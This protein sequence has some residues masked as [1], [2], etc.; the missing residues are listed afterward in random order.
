MKNKIL[1]TKELVISIVGI[2]L[3]SCLIILPPVFR[4]TFKREKPI[5]PNEKGPILV[6]TCSKNNIKN[7]N[8]TDNQV[9]S[10]AHQDGKLIS[11]IDEK[12]RIY[13]DSI[14]YQSE[15]AEYGK[16]V[17]ALTII[18]GYTYTATPVDNTSSVNIKESFDLARFADTTIT[19]PGS[20]DSK[21]VKSKYNY[22]AT[23]EDIQ[24]SLVAQG[25]TCK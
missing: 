18:D 13:Y 25:Y 3:L 6:L 22:E 1:T 4:V 20:S 5:D 15:K 17:T 21:E 14:V 23:I 16:L 19:I 2:V 10:L 12:E 24:I 7:T 9:Y 8:Y 11:Y